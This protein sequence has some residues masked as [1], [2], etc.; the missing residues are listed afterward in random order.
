M[1][2]KARLKGLGMA[3]LKE[4]LYEIVPINGNIDDSK[5]KKTEDETCHING[6]SRVGKELGPDQGQIDCRDLYSCRR[7]GDRWKRH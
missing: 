7:R 4:V 1:P 5:D 6:G 2:R 3:L